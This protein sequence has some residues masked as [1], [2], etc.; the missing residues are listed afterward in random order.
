MLNFKSLA[1]TTL[2]ATTL[3]IAAPTPKA[4]AGALCTHTQGFDIPCTD[5]NGKKWNNRTEWLLGTLPDCRY[6]YGRNLVNEPCKQNGNLYKNF[7]ELH[8]PKRTAP[9]AAPT[10]T[11]RRKTRQEFTNECLYFPNGKSTGNYIKETNYGNGI[12]CV[13]STGAGIG[14]YSFN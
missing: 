13:N 11:F 9:V 14:S 12:R 10:N 7:V 6:T 1:L 8:G 2:A 4:Q 5:P 3:T